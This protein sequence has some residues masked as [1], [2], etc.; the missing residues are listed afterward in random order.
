MLRIFPVFKSKGFVS[1]CFPTGELPFTLLGFNPGYASPSG[2]YPDANPPSEITGVGVA[3]FKKTRLGLFSPAFSR[4]HYKTV[5]S[6]ELY[7]R[8]MKSL[9]NNDR[10]DLKIPWTADRKRSTKSQHHYSTQV[11]RAFPV[12][13]WLPG[14]YRSLYNSAS[15]LLKPAVQLE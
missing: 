12:E 11:V 4:K 14:M 9:D 7:N 3:W 2:R 13:K 5:I 6:L 1:N 15:H 10:S 8:G